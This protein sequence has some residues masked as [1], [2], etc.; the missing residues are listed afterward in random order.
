MSMMLFLT[1]ILYL[2]FKIQTKKK[3]KMAAKKSGFQMVNSICGSGISINIQRDLKS[4]HSNSDIFKNFL[5][6]RWSIY[7]VYNVAME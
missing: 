1:A 5:V 7:L 4:D 3:F 6:F 2:P